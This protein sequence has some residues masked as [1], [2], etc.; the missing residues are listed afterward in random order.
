MQ[1][2]IDRESIDCL[3]FVFIQIEVKDRYVALV[4]YLIGGLY[5]SSISF[6]ALT[7]FRLD[8]FNQKS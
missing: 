8:N 3:L 5:S 6:F 7:I 2:G 1:G 4:R